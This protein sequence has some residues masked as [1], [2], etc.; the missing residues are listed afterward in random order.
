MAKPAT[1]FSLSPITLAILFSGQVSAEVPTL[2]TQVVTA[3]HWEEP[4]SK[5]PASISQIELDARK[6]D[7]TKIEK[8]VSNVRVEHSSVQTRIAI[9]GSSGY[10]TS[11]QQPVGYYLND[12]ALP[13]GATQLPVM[14]NVEPIEVIKGPQGD[15][16][17]RHSEAGVVKVRQQSLN[18]QPSLEVG[19]MMGYTQ[20]ANGRQMANSVIV[21]AENTLVEDVLAASLALKIDRG[22]G[23]NHNLA[24][25]AKDGGRHNNVSG[26]IAFELA[27]NDTTDILLRSYT[28]DQELGKARLRYLTGPAATDRQVTNHNTKSVE[29]RDSDI[30][31]LRIDHEI[32]DIEL[33]SITGTTRFDRGFTTDLDLTPAPVPATLMDM[34][35]RMWSQEL[36]LSNHLSVDQSG[37]WLAGVY[38]YQQDTDVDFTLGGTPM[39]PR[40]QRVTGIDQ[41]GGA[42]FGQLEWQFVNNWFF[43]SG[44]RYERINKTGE[45]ALMRQMNH[46]Y[47]SDLDQSIWLPKL[48]LSYQGESH[49]AYATIAKGYLPGGFNYASA[50]SLSSFT[51]NEERSTNLEIGYKTQLVNN[52]LN[53]TSALFHIRT[54]DKQITD[55]LPGFEQ[56]ISNAA[57][58][59]SYGVELTADYQWHSNLNTYIS[60][61][62]M[63]AK[64]DDYQQNVF[65]GS[66]FVVNNLSGNR[67]PLAPKYTYSL[68]IDYQPK[69]G[70]FA[71][72]NASGSSKYYFDVANT[73]EHPK[74]LTFDASTGYKTQNVTLAVHLENLFDEERYS[75]AVRTPS[76][77]VVEDS[78]ERF[79]GASLTMNW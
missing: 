41:R 68:G 60:I 1:A 19:L 30:H 7:I 51:Y 16:Y 37:R 12:V 14:V 17:G 39:M 73:L 78:H 75:R 24:N 70:W 18:W 31:S 50:R 29:N 35:D 47:S 25:D 71:S 26:N 34:K 43:T 54:K 69:S 33:T 45:Q 53:L 65:N 67:L 13:L 46:R 64:A 63:E 10:D 36:R 21:A 55:I 20:G 42:G 44:L 22:D 27:A 72:L 57:Q 6:D 23:P 49:T 2:E 9:R 3:R 66:R 4:S 5:V 28:S 59:T 15:L 61:G 48:S 38:F 74:Y 56:T 79:I 32:G 77:A 58:T 8:R 76:G 62:T 11:L 40:T 52:K